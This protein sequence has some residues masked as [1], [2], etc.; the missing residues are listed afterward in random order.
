MRFR[1]SYQHM[2]Q[3]RV[4]RSF[5]TVEQAEEF[6]S[7]NALIFPLPFMVR[8]YEVRNDLNFAWLG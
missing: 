2:R 1:V 8:H 4:S 5:E 7:N 6:I 3:Y